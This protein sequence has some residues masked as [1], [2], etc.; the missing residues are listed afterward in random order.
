M[1][2][3][4]EEYPDKVQINVR[5]IL[6]AEGTMRKMRD[7]RYEIQPPGKVRTYTVYQNNGHWRCDPCQ[8]GKTEDSRP[9]CHIGAVLVHIGVLQLPMPADVP[10]KGD[11]PRNWTAINEARQMEPKL[12]PLLI[13]ELVATIPERKV[14][15]L[16]RPPIPLRDLA[17]AALVYVFEKRSMAYAT[18]ALECSLYRDHVREPMSYGALSPFLAHPDTK[19]ML[20]RLLAISAAPA[21]SYVTAGGPDGTGF[22]QFNFYNYAEKRIQEKLESGAKVDKKDKDRKPRRRHHITAV[23]FVMWEVAVVPAVVVKAKPAWLR[24]HNRSAKVAET[25]KPGENNWFM[26]L[27]ERT[28]MVFPGLARISA[29]KGF[30]Q[31]IHY[32][33]GKTRGIDIQIE[34]KAGTGGE[35]THK[36][37]ANKAMKDKFREYELDPEGHIKKVH[38]REIQESAMNAVETVFGGGVRCRDHVAQENEIR[39]KW[40][41]QNLRTLLF[42]K[43]NRG[44]TIDFRS[45][46]Y[47]IDARPWVTL[48]DL[49]LKYMQRRADHILWSE[50]QELGFSRSTRLPD[51]DMPAGGAKSLIGRPATT[52]NC[53]RTRQ[54]SRLGNQDRL[55]GLD[56]AA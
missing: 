15:F 17:Y 2:I 20:E 31:T 42:E 28:R 41:L 46:A 56:H 26:A 11:A 51:F 8:G 44:L 45:E 4:F 1:P 23:A 43:Y 13:A 7:G 24:A 50:G 27:A 35:G 39:L 5:R 22:Q 49:K 54:A 6:N 37:L 36:G 53:G 40:I 55:T 10:L 14:A 16:G 32:L 18:G 33:Y 34:R 29:D 21:K 12:M 19:E 48:E 38:Q 25:E 3:P 30:V 9:C 52:S 47:A